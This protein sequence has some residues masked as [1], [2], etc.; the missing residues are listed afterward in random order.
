MDWPLDGESGGTTPDN[1]DIGF[2]S[3]LLRERSRIDDRHAECSSSPGVESTG[4]RSAFA[5]RGFL[6]GLL[7]SIRHSFQ[8]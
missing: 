4:F 6:N 1:A 7:A 2:D 8:R 3:V 5:Q